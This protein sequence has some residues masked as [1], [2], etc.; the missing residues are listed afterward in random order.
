MTNKPRLIKAG[1]YYLATLEVLLFFKTYHL[2]KF[3]N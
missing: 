2:D 1:V 3:C